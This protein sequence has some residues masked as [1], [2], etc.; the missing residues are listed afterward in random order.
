VLRGQRAQLIQHTFSRGLV[1][2]RDR[3]LAQDAVYL[4]LSATANE[5][6]LEEPHCPLRPEIHRQVEELGRQPLIR[7]ALEAVPLPP[8]LAVDL[9]G[10]LAAQVA[11]RVPVMRQA[12]RAQKLGG[13][14]ELRDLAGGGVFEVPAL[15]FEHHGHGGVEVGAARRRRVHAARPAAYEQQDHADQDQGEGGEDE[16]EHL[17]VGGLSFLGGLDVG[18]DAGEALGGIQ[19]LELVVEPVDAAFELLNAIGLLRLGAVA[20]GEGELNAEEEQVEDHHRAQRLAERVVVASDGGHRPSYAVSVPGLSWSAVS[21]RRP[22]LA[23]VA[24]SAAD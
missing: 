21:S 4:E 5:R 24:L 10:L 20:H 17:A 7:K 1:D 16:Q 3:A 18:L 6:L 23:R 14:A 2:S 22:A 9:D 8:V 11:D 12:D 13:E 19:A 15:V